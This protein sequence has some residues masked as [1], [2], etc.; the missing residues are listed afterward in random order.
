VKA[1]GQPKAV[2]NW[3]MGDLM[4]LLNGENREFSDCPLRPSQLADMLQLI[5]KGTISGK[6]AKTVFE[7]MYR[8]GKNA[9]EIVKDKGL[10]QIS[11]ESAIE[12]IVDE[13]IAKHP[14]EA[15]RLKAGEEKLLGFFV[16]QAMK[17][18]K[19]KANPQVL[20]EMLR[21]KLS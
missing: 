21:K 10:V 15:E 17:A 8:T 9:E 16:G 12:K 6:I 7:E 18:M 5:D 11:D 19:G 4:R 13:L 1:G 20:N 14:K 3:M 2:S